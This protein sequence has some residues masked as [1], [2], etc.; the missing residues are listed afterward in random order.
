MKKVKT[1]AHTLEKYLFTC[2]IGISYVPLSDE[3]DPRACPFIPKTLPLLEVPQCP[4]MSPETYAQD[5]LKLHAEKISVCIF[6]PGRAFDTAGTRHGR[7][8]G[9][10]SIADCLRK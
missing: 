1:A 7:G 5:L 4:N 2:A 3:P 8:G 10:E 6:A 9:R